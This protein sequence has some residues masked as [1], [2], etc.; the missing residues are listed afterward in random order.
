MTLSLIGF[1]CAFLLLCNIFVSLGMNT[2]LRE[3]NKKL[4]TYTEEL[5]VRLHN[6]YAKEDSLKKEIHRLKEHE[7]Q[8]YRLTFENLALRANVFSHPVP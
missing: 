2:W 6:S 3:T 8:H 4:K 5:T 7:K 1:L